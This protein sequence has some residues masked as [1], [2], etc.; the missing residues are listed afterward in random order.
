MTSAEIG[1]WDPLVTFEPKMLEGR[2]IA[3][4]KDLTI[5]PAVAKIHGRSFS[6]CRD[7]LQN[8]VHNL[9]PEVIEALTH[10]R[11][12]PWLSFGA[13]RDAKL[14]LEFF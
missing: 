3:Q 4:I 12:R 9:T 14:P 8:A 7:M 5:V 6:R 2:L 10:D 13:Y 1:V 11:T